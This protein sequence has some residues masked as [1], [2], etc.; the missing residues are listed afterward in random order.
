M[1]M[2]IYS[3]VATFTRLAGNIVIRCTNHYT[4]LFLSCFSKCRCSMETDITIGEEPPAL[5]EGSEAP[6]A[7]ESPTP[8]RWVLVCV[9]PSVSS[10]T[11]FLD[12]LQNICTYVHAHQEHMYS[13]FCIPLQHNQFSDDQV[14][15]VHFCVHVPTSR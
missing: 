3:F 6:L 15:H 12:A 10:V 8:P 7:L 14:M 5:T 13:L 11:T 9:L 2:Y 4:L 1:F